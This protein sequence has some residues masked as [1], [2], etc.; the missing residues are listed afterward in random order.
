M[1]DNITQR[2]DLASEILITL[3]KDT[4]ATEIYDILEMISD[5][6]NQ[7]IQDNSQFGKGA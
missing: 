6:R 2:L 1:T 4:K 5:Y 3:A 7:Y